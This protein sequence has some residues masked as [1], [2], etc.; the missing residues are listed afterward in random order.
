RERYWRVPLPIWECGKCNSKEIIGGIDELSSKI[1]EPRN[2]YW[3]MR[4]GQAKSNVTH[5]INSRTDPENKLTTIGRNNVILS[6]ERLKKQFQRDGEKID[7]IVSSDIPRARETA[8]IAASI[9]GIKKVLID[10]KFGEIKLGKLEG[11]RDSKYHEFFPTYESKFENRPEKGESLRDLRGRMWEAVCDYEKKYKDKNILIVSHE[12]PIWMFYHAVR[13]ISE[14]QAITEKEKRGADFIDLAGT[15]KIEIRNL[16][17]DGSGLADL[18]K[19]YIDGITLICRKCRSKTRRV[20]E[21]ID[22]WYDSGAMPFAELHYPFE[23]KELVDRRKFY[24]AD[25]ISEG[26]DQTRG[27]FYT[28][29]AIA[30]ALGFEA[31]YKNVIS[32]GLINDK[33]GQKMSKSKGNIVQPMDP[34]NKYGVDAVRWYFYT[35]NPPG[36][37]KNFDETEII[38]SF[39]RMH[40]IIYNSLVFYETYGRSGT[41]NKSKNIL[42][43]WILSRL[44][45]AAEDVGK[46]LDN[47]EIREAALLLESFV[48]DL[49]RW[50]IRRSRRRF[51]KPKN[52]TEL[53]EASGTLGFVI[54]DMAKLMAPFTPFFSEFIYKRM[55]KGESVHLEDWPKYGKSSVDED[56][57]KAMEWVRKT[58]SLAL[59]KRAELKIKVRQ[60][61]S[62]LKIKGKKPKFMKNESLLEI[63]KEEVNVKKIIFDDRLPANVEFD[64]V[65]TPELKREGIMR[66]TIRMIQDLRQKSRMKPED[67][68]VLMMELPKG[69]EPVISGNEKLLKAE[70]GAKN[71]SYGRSTKVD[72]ETD[73]KLDGLDVWL[74]VRKVK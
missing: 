32:L 65:I 45:E 47:Y 36:E 41:K 6:A 12:Y 71:I 58:A 74:A 13:G 20:P 62:S 19:P 25:Y 1:G 49:S 57:L 21:V 55:D 15:E 42:D 24:P 31:P 66:E 52:A 33:F 11:L 22:V 40:L 69:I 23:N 72:A 67:K 56:L 10:K 17:R 2:R 30:T 46:K 16:S 28:L 38:K 14:K 51:Q 44:A 59:A 27:W 64:S 43:R 34:I 37:T 18:H 3:V 73:G 68:I 70:V 50:Y 60:P 54:A 48:D 35:V 29:L 4:H 63:L 9:I 53:N 26:M 61:L 7:L 39:R 5:I 8:R